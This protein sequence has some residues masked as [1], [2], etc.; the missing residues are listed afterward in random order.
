MVLKYLIGEM[1]IWAFYKMTL[2]A[3]A[4]FF[5]EYLYT[6]HHNRLMLLCSSTL[7]PWILT[8]S[9]LQTL[10]TEKNL[11]IVSR[12][13]SQDSFTLKDPTQSSAVLK[14]DVIQLT[15]GKSLPK[16]VLLRKKVIRKIQNAWLQC[17]IGGSAVLGL[18]CRKGKKYYWGKKKKVK[19]WFCRVGESNFGIKTKRNKTHVNRIWLLTN[20]L[21]GF[22]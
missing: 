18:E 2:W 7:N 11:I 16:K 13:N 14:S 8:Y 22:D 10:Y 1:K 3:L 17:W 20:F 19:C 21:R 5:Q 4:C 9:V 12:D 15:W 6:V